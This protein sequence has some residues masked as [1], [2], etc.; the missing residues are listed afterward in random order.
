M[1]EHAPDEV[2]EI[3]SASSALTL[4][5]AQLGQGEDPRQLEQVLVVVGLLLQ[6]CARQLFTS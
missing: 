5:T 6:L 2:L 1:G 3:G 4:A